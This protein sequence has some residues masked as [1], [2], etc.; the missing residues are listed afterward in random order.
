M[1]PYS[2]WIKQLGFAIWNTKEIYPKTV[3]AATD[4][5]KQGGQLTIATPILEGLRD[6]NT[7]LPR[8]AIVEHLLINH[9]RALDIDGNT[10]VSEPVLDIE[11]EREKLQKQLPN[12]KVTNRVLS[13]VLGFDNIGLNNLKAR[14]MQAPTDQPKDMTVMMQSPEFV[15]SEVKQAGDSFRLHG[16]NITINHVERNLETGRVDISY[17][18]QGHTVR[19]Q[20][21]DL[22]VTTNAPESS[23][24]YA[25]SER[26][27]GAPMP[28]KLLRFFVKPG[29][30]V[31]KGQNLA[32]IEAMKM[33]NTLRAEQDGEVESVRDLDKSAS[34]VERGECLVTLK[35]S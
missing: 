27:V 13:T 6:W 30:R 4:Y 7:L 21:K 33:E 31:K 26:D 19:M 35:P 20:G 9:H 10:P 12:I 18:F 29:D 14:D 2:E 28:G 32:T 11:A 25:T 15:Y 16:E 34:M 24:K 5:I 17:R 3:E 22:R 23:I 1:T 8:P